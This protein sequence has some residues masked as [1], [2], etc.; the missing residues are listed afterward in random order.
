[1]RDERLQ[2]ALEGSSA[3]GNTRRMR[4]WC[5][6]WLLGIGMLGC[7][8]SGQTG[9]LSCA[10]PDACACT[11]LTAHILVKARVVSSDAET[12]MATLEVEQVLNTSPSFDEADVSRRLV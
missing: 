5:W 4:S 1:M 9:S 11:L 2:S 7:G 6:W 3:P 8:G 10:R 12:Q